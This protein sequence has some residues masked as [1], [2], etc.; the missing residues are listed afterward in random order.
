LGEF[1]A[2]WYFFFF[3]QFFENDKFS[4]N[5]WLLFS[6]EN[7]TYQQ[8]RQKYLWA[9]F[10]VIFFTKLSGHTA[11]SSDE[12]DA[13]KSGGENGSKIALWPLKLH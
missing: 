8:F 12:F 5:F 3:G 6:Q 11:S 2:L 7:F 1:S 9:T 10:W 4:T 13:K